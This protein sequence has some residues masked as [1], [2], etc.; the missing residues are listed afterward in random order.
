MS[1]RDQLANALF[2]GRPFRVLP[3][4]LVVEV[5]GDADTTLMLRKLGFNIKE[6]DNTDYLVAEVRNFE[7][8]LAN[9]RDFRD[10]LDGDLI[11]SIGSADIQEVKGFNLS[12]SLTDVVERVEG[13][14]N[15]QL[16]F[17]PTTFGPLSLGIDVEAEPATSDQADVGEVLERIGAYDAHETTR[18]EGAIIAVFDTSFCEDFF[19]SERIIDTYAGPNGD[20]DAFGA[21]EEGHGTMCAYLAAGNSDES[22]LDWDG[23]APEAD[24]LLARLTDDDGALRYTAE[25]WDW[26]VGHI[27]ESDRP[28]ISS[29]SYGVPLCSARGMNLC[30]ATTTSIARVMNRRDDHQAFYAAGNEANYCGHRLSGA[31]NGINGINSDDSSFSVG[32]LL[33]DSSEAQ[34]Y[35]SH[36]WGSCTSFQSDPKPDFSSAIPTVVPYGCTTSA[37]TTRSG[38]SGGGTS[39]ATP[40]TA[41]CGALVASVAGSAEKPMLEE[42]LED[43]ATLPRPTQVNF[44]L[45]HDARFGNGQVN[46]DAAVNS[47]R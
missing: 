7:D 26:L 20:G 14:T 18:G 22:G 9:I 42:A 28:V 45:G 29:H 3:E 21:P 35:S 16:D 46:V 25:A 27:R 38:T 39:A 31:T 15:V 37:L 30:S 23:V 19:D 17:T 43:T 8:V 34:P 4:R 1:L 33:G 41:G 24:L 11:D 6:F 32:A 13:V 2:P 12:N 40:I 44:F 47:V 5:G 10:E 36:G